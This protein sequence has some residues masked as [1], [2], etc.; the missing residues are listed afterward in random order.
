MKNGDSFIIG[1][2]KQKDSSSKSK[3]V[4]KIVEIIEFIQSQISKKI[5][6]FILFKGKS[7][8]KLSNLFILFS[9]TNLDLIW[10]LAAIY[11]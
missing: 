10:K 6:Y 1:N 9:P 2:K 8:C 5:A 11:M 4:S 7:K 3:L